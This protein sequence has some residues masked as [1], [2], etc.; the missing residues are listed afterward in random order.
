MSE[1]ITKVELRRIIRDAQKELKE[2][3]AVDRVDA[4]VKKW[5]EAHHLKIKLND[6]C[7]A[8]NTTLVKLMRVP[9]FFYWAQLRGNQKAVD[10][11]ETWLQEA[12]RR[13]TSLE[14]MKE[15]ADDLKRKRMATKLNSRKTSR[16]RAQKNLEQFGM[17]LGDTEDKIG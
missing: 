17:G 1:D 5:E 9:D 14:K 12:V 7:K 3:T 15:R 8:D 11:D 10:R 13:G 6:I 2:L 4:E 16:K